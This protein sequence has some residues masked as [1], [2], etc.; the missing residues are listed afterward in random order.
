[1]DEKPTAP[2]MTTLEKLTRQSFMSR[3]GS[4]GLATA[5][6]TVISPVSASTLAATREETHLQQRSIDEFKLTNCRV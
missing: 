4:L 5:A 3:A 2:P 6:A 1:M